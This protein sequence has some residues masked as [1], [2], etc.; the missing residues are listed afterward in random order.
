MKLRHYSAMASAF[1]AMKTKS[2]AQIIYTNISDATIYPGTYSSPGTYALDLN[3]DGQ[4]DFNF[5]FWK[6][7]FTTGNYQINFFTLNEYLSSNPNQVEGY[8]NNA[9][10]LHANVAINATQPW[11]SASQAYMGYY[12]SSFN[13]NPGSTLFFSSGSWV[14]I[15]NRYLGLRLIQGVD[16]FYGWVRMDV[17]VTDSVVIKDYAYN[18]VAGE[19]I[20]AGEGDIPT[21]SSVVAGGNNNEF[22]IFPN[23]AVSELHLFIRKP[24]DAN[25]TATII[26]LS[27]RKILSQI[28]SSQKTSLDVSS[29]EDGIYL[30]ELRSRSNTILKKFEVRH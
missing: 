27:G 26:D 1:L 3:N 24:L 30:L 22:E 7:H 9:M 5:I 11:I 17:L 23:P 6:S 29:L 12:A 18:S 2:D 21:S 13:G 16:T 14:H 8:P 4:T 25:V 20:L 15:N 28:I 19:E 10:E